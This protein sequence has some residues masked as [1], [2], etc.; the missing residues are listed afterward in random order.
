ME[1]KRTLEHAQSFCCFFP[2]VHAYLTIILILLTTYHLYSFL[3]VFY[4]LTALTLWVMGLKIYL[5]GEMMEW[6]KFI[7]LI[8]QMSLS[9][10]LIR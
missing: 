2:Q 3:K 5:L 6:W 1:K 8:M 4:V 9:Y 10:D 7:A